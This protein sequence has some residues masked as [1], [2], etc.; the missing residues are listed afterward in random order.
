MIFATFLFA[1]HT[2]F[3]WQMK[4]RHLGFFDALKWW[5]IWKHLKAM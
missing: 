3:T 5:L 4:K 2:G 1:H